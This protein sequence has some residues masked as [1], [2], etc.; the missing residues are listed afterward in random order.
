MQHIFAE[1]GLA[2][3]NHDAASF[4]SRVSLSHCKDLFFDLGS[5]VQGL[6]QFSVH[7]AAAA[8]PQPLWTFRGASGAMQAIRRRRLNLKNLL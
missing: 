8:G 1:L 4:V 5:L 3:G 2:E 7:L 6:G